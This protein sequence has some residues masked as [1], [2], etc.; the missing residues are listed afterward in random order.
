MTQRRWLGL[1]GIVA[2]IL[3]PVAFVAVAGKTPS[4][5]ASAD[6]VLTF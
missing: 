6:K 4:E 2:S 3:I 5:K 1:C